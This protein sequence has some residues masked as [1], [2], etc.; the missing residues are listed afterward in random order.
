[1]E[2]YYLQSFFMYKNLKWF[3]TS[4]FIT[5]E[6]FIQIQLLTSTPVPINVEDCVNH[7]ICIYLKVREHPGEY[8]CIIVLFCF[9]SSCLCCQSCCC[10]CVYLFLFSFFFCR[11][12]KKWLWAKNE[13]IAWKANDSLKEEVNEMLWCQWLINLSSSTLRKTHLHCDGILTLSKLKF[14][15]I[16]KCTTC[17]RKTHL[18]C[19]VISNVSRLK[20][21]DITKSTPRASSLMESVYHPY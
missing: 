16:T 7:I 8:G 4:K 18:H 3:V 2:A 11:K 6:G 15:D 10:C 13:I 12:L 14:D 5:K 19:D 1:M 20:F 21:D 17:L 9:L